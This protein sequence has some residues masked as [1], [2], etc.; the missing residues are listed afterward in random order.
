MMLIWAQHIFFYFIFKKEWE[1]KIH[2]RSQKIQKTNLKVLNFFSSF[3][4]TQCFN[5]NHP[6]KSLLF[7]YRAIELFYLSLFYQPW[8][9]YYILKTNY[10]FWKSI[11]TTF[12][13]M[14]YFEIITNFTYFILIVK[15]L[16]QELLFYMYKQF[17]TLKKFTLKIKIL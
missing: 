15:T 13:I 8:L 2:T 14:K 9:N 3:T 4:F 12:P 1:W 5:Q 17:S 6:L 16:K 11:W 7:H 10:I